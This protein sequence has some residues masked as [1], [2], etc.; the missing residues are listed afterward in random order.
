MSG[1]HTSIPLIPGMNGWPVDVG[2]PQIFTALD[3]AIIGVSLNEN[4]QMIPRKS[5]SMVVGIG[6]SSFN[7]DPL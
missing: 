1:L 4:A 2:Q 5:I 3:A 6:K 7:F